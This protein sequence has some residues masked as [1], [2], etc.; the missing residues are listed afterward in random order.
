MQSE[1]YREDIREILM[2][3][4][5]GDIMSEE[6]EVRARLLMQEFLIPVVAVRFIAWDITRVL[7]QD[8]SVAT[9]GPIFGDYIDDNSP[10]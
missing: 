10:W 2:A 6:L 7:M 8:G 4:Y 9:F 5:Y 1:Q 3:Y